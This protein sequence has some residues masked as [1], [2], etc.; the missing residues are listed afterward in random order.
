MT[1]ADMH[2]AVFFLLQNLALQLGLGSDASLRDSNL[3]ASSF[4]VYA[5]DVPLRFSAAPCVSLER[6][7]PR[8]AT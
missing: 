1:C 6:L 3:H 5:S 7:A 2:G 8:A 4:F